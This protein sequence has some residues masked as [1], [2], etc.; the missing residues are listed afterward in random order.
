MSNVIRL[1]DTE[2]ANPLIS[3]V[4]KAGAPLLQGDD[5]FRT[6]VDTLPAAVYTTDAAGR[7]HILQRGGRDALGASAGARQERMVRV[8][9]AVL[10]RRPA[11]A[12]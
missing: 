1:G 9:A 5:F 12:A 8:M 10:A 3:L 7:D 4:A 2:P 11:A 6:L